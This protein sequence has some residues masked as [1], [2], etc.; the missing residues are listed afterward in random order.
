MNTESS[1]ISMEF[2]F[3]NQDKA[4]TGYLLSMDEVELVKNM[5]RSLKSPEDRDFL[6]KIADKEFITAEEKNQMQQIFNKAAK[7]I[8]KEASLSV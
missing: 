1:I 8:K 6:N 7:R 2:N 3:S 5:A 4:G